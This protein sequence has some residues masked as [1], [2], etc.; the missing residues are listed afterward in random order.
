MFEKF[1]K[2]VEAKWEEMVQGNPNLFIITSYLNLWESYLTE[3]DGKRGNPIYRINSEHNC[4]CCRSF[5]KRV[6]GVF[7]VNPNGSISTVWDIIPTG[8]PEY[9]NAAQLLATLVRQEVAELRYRPFLTKHNEAGARTSVEV[10]IDGSGEAA[11]KTWNHFYAKVPSIYTRKS[12]GLEVG[13]T[14]DAI[15]HLWTVFYTLKSSAFDRVLKMINANTL[16][17]GREFKER[18]EEAKALHAVLQ[19]APSVWAAVLNN[20]HRCRFF[21]NSS[22]GSLVKDLSDGVDERT[23]LGLYASKVSAAT[24]Q[25]STRSATQTSMDRLKLALEELG[26]IDSINRRL[27][28]EADIPVSAILFVDS[29]TSGAL[30]PDDPFAV[31]SSRMTKTAT[32]L[33]INEFIRDVIPVAKKME[34]LINSDVLPHFMTMT[35]ADNS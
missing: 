3:V 9:D 15:N 19:D 11:R 34:L 13:Q 14:I 6:G 35:A 2:A 25:R 16:Y 22:I 26:A 28:T 24:Y 10:F 5:M 20:H 23:A 27:A 31:T 32:T 4:S 7:S 18:V 17:R 30:R 33:N 1:S 29:D 8:I 12:T 21:A